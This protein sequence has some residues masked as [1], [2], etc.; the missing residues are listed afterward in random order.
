[1]LEISKP[2]RDLNGD[3]IQP[4]PDVWM[5]YVPAL[6][7][8]QPASVCTLLKTRSLLPL[9]VAVSLEIYFCY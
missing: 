1:M 3:L 4:P 9:L 2:E 7:N 6:P 8:N 5:V